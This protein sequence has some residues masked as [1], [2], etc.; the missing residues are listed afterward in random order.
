MKFSPSQV[1]L[2]FLLIERAEA[3]LG[4]L[5]DGQRADLLLDNMMALRGHDEARALLEAI[6][7]QEAA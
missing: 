4:P 1:A 7:E 6:N 5:S 2:A 3:M